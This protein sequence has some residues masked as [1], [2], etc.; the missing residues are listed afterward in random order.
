MTRFDDCLR[1]GMMDANIAQYEYAIQKAESHELDASPRYFRERMRLLADPWGWARQQEQNNQHRGKRLNW[2][3]IAII[4]ALLLL[5]ACAYAVVTGQFSQWFSRLGMDPE[6]PETSEDVL[7][8]TGTVIQQSQTVGDATVTLNAALWDGTDVWL[9]IVIESPD[10]PEEVQQYTPLYTGDCR[11]ILQ[12]DQWMEYER[13]RLKEQELDMT[14]EQI[15][16]DLRSRLAS[17]DRMDRL[18]LSWPETREGN[19]LTFQVSDMLMSDW[20]TE[21]KRPELTLHLENIATY[22]D[23][24]VDEN[25]VAQDPEPG[26]VFVEGPFDLT[27]TLEEPILPVRYDGAD[28]EVT[29]MDIPLRFTGFQLSVTNLTAFYEA[30]DPVEQLRSGE[31]LTPE[32]T[33]QIQAAIMDIMQASYAS[34]QGLWTKDGKYVDFTDSDGSGGSAGGSSGGGSGTAE[35]YYPYPIDP[36]TVTAVDIA[37]TRVELSELEAVLP[38]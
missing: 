9:S 35:L 30:P 19:T 25:G 10:I 1:R 34:V 15:E 13:G 4:A 18:W 2:R 21:T 6:A 11:L 7:S 26:M 5:S 22:V 38:E 37:G 14:P 3:L 23:G 12:D 36:A 16:E 20:F 27:F 17:G 31:T 28:I 32:E 33:R 29:V 24:G 8:R